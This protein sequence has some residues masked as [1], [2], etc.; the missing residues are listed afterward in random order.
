MRWQ[1]MVFLAATV[2]SGCADNAVLELT[3]GLPPQPSDA[4]GPLGDDPRFAFVQVRSAQSGA[5]FDESWSGAEPFDGFALQDM[6]TTEMISIVGEPVHYE[7]TLMV[8]VRFCTSADC[9]AL[10]D[11]MAPEA[12][13][14]VPRVF[15]SLERTSYEWRINEVPEGEPALT[16]GRRCD[17]AGCVAGGEPESYCRI[18][19]SHFCEPPRSR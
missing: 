13:L 1:W 5:T 14:T 8:R 10:G 6:A 7:E 3:L 17:V 2:L 19:G 9:S 11:D 15:Y 4:S 12:R 18:E 16:E